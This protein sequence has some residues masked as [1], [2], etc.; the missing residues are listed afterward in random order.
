ML[1]FEDETVFMSKQKKVFHFDR[2]NAIHNAKSKNQ[3]KN[4]PTNILKNLM[5][6]KTPH[7]HY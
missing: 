2:L 6:I 5:N 7:L 1:F 3:W 4:P